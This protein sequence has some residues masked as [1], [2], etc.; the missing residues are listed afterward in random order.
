M[1]IFSFVG[2]FS[3][4]RSFD[5]TFRRGE[6]RAR[7]LKNRLVRLLT[8]TGVFVWMWLMILLGLF[9]ARSLGPGFLKATRILVGPLWFLLVYLLV[10]ALT[11]ASYR[12]HRRFG[13]SALAVAVF[14]AAAMD[15]L[16]FSFSLPGAGWA[17]VVFVWLLA[18]QLGYF[19]ADRTL[20]RA[21]QWVTL[22]WLCSASPDSWVLPCP[23]CTQRAWWAQGSR[24]CQT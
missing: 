4:F 19:Y 1:P 15:V 8:P 9:L 22:Y 14:F 12:L 2:G 18:H 20:V 23:G 7:F 17:N 21:R 16:R 6:S 13:M 10:T 24:R 5:N 11:P 3:D